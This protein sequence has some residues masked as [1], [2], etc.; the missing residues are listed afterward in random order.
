MFSLVNDPFWN[1]FPPTVIDA[2]NSG[3]AKTDAG[4]NGRI[5]LGVSTA[6][7]SPKFA[8]QTVAA[9]LLQSGNDK[10]LNPDTATY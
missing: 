10:S 3:F 2:D 8:L 6:G 7:R 4:G 5:Y 9:S 1:Q